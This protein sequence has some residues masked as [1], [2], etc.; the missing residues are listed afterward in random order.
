MSR[1]SLVLASL[2]LAAMVLCTFSKVPNTHAAGADGTWMPQWAGAPAPRVVVFDPHK[3]RLVG[4]GSA[5]GSPAS[6]QVWVLPVDG[7]GSWTPI[8]TLG[9]SPKRFGDGSTVTFDPV[10]GRFLLYGGFGSDGVREETYGELWALTIGATA[11]WVELSSISARLLDSTAGR[12]ALGAAGAVAIGA[13][14]YRIMKGAKGDVTQEL[15][16]SGM[17]A[18]R[19]SVTRRLGMIGEVGRGIGIGVIGIFLLRAAVFINAN[20]ATGLDGALR[21]LTRNAEGRAVVV[22]VAVGFLLYGVLCVETFNRRTLQ[23]P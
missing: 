10:R 3:R 22:V 12:F 19:R 23:A 9:S 20:E 15:D 8:P 1:A 18:K 11:E 17:S 21:R 13:G 2:V 5:N 7:G 6:Q 4:F 14:L 16:L